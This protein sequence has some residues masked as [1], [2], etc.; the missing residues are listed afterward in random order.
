MDTLGALALGT[1]PPTPALLD[2]SPVGKNY[3][4]INS[5]MWRSI[6]LGGAYQLIVLFVLL[7]SGHKMINVEEGSRR[8]YTLLFNAFVFCQVFNE[9]NSRRI[10]KGGTFH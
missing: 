8:H 4:L 1:E 6:L 7:Y 10:N 3:P 5:L 9:I 2:R